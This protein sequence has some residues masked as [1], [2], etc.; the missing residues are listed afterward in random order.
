M[1][2]DDVLRKKIYDGLFAEVV[3]PDPGNPYRDTDTG[4]EILMVDVHG[5]P[6]Q[7]YGAGILYPQRVRQINQL[8]TEEVADTP[9]EIPVV[10]QGD[11]TG[12]TETSAMTRDDASPTDDPVD[13][14]N[15]FMQSAMGFTFM[16][17]LNS[18]SGKIKITASAAHY[19]QSDAQLPMRR[20][21][22]NGVLTDCR[23]RDGNPVLRRC[24]IRRPL[25]LGILDIDVNEV[26]KEKTEVVYRDEENDAWL[27]FQLINRST[28]NDRLAS[29]ATYTATIINNKIASSN[30]KGNYL[31][32]CSLVIESKSDDLIIPYHERVSGTDTAEEKS[33]TLLYRKKHVFAIGHGCA[34]VW[35]SD[36]L[37]V[38]KIST[39]VIPD[40]EMPLV[41]PTS[42]VELS[43]FDLSDLG[44]WQK[45]LQSLESLVTLYGNW[46]KSLNDEANGL[47]PF[48]QDSAHANIEKCSETLERIR[49]GLA[50]LKD[51]NNITALACFK[52][53]NRAMLWQQ[54]RSKVNQRKWIRN[55]NHENTTF[56]LTPLNDGKNV[57]ISLSQFNQTSTAERPVGRWRPFQLAFIL[58]NLKSVWNDNDGERGIIDLIWFPTGGGKTEA[59]LGLTAFQIFSRRIQGDGM[60]KINALGTS[61]IMRYTL[62]LLTVQQY[63]RAASLICACDLIR[64]EN[65]NELGHK[66]ISIG[67][68]VGGKNTPNT[69]KDALAAYNRLHDDNNEAYNFIVL[70]CPC[71]GAQ[72]GKVDNPI[73]Q[74]R[75]KGL[76]RTDGATGRTYFKCENPDCE[77]GNKELPLYV[78]DDE[79]YN[80]SPTLV[81]G[82][83]D[84]FA[85]IP[86]KPDSAK[87]FGFR[88]DLNTHWTRIKPPELI[89]QDELHL[90]SGPLGT[91]VGLYETLVQ[92]LCNN[93]GMLQPP[94][95]PERENLSVFKP[96]KIV[97]SSATIS[98][99]GDQVKALYASDRLNIFPPQAL[100]F[101]NTWFSEEKVISK[102][103]PGRLY[104][105]IC[106]S[107]YPSAQTAI[108]RTYAKVLQTV[109]VNNTVPEID[110][111]WT[112]MGY[113]NSI[114]ELGGA[115]SLVYGDI[116]ERLSQIHA[117]DLIL[118]QVRRMHYEE[119]TSRISNEKI[120]QILKKLETQSGNPDAIAIDICL[121]TNMIATG[122]DISRLGLMFIHG[123]P[124]TTAEYIQASSRVGRAVPSG[125]GF[126]VTLYSPSKPRDK[127]IY[128]HFLAYHAR[129]YANVE[130]T[131][132]TPFTIS[133]RERA[134]HAV[135]IGLIR[136][137]SNGQLHDEALIGNT[138]F[139][140]LSAKVKDIVKKR[141]EFIDYNEYGATSVMIDAFLH[142]WQGGFHY[143]GDAM[144]T[145]ANLHDR[146]PLMY[147]AGAEFP[148]KMKLR[149][150]KTPTSMR[151]VDSESN[152]EIL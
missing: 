133:V 4:E 36:S 30:D 135:I 87:I 60:F 101:G 78:V 132:V 7:K 38:S 1:R 29:T 56:A 94:F 86:W 104:V 51:K 69:N 150:V 114:S 84:K 108:A 63:E 34:A 88:V 67:L 18:E 20:I 43:M 138:D 147:S 19:I 54:Q 73:P 117:R 128:E 46:I 74:T 31:Y 146:L 140:E 12:D 123:Q 131:S 119:L 124:K 57:F 13:L 26:T 48:Y 121:A 64:E 127:S 10:G 16:V 93:Y 2:A 39:S 61:V 142:K 33:M 3:G 145:G 45:G 55:G 110:Y 70:K 118:Q 106:P 44:D 50:F 9:D 76:F 82:T 72:I 96:P 102:E 14:A 125:P 137:F 109:D 37:T 91:M 65:K 47:P 134:L 32:Q 126:I 24:W 28:A 40:Y 80:N 107:G 22:Q 8:D 23:N 152:I 81:L 113:F 42:H 130:P 41:A 35:N 151:G 25:P 66:P 53:M 83:V 148:E 85:M 15:Q 49:G 97:A 11:D 77:Y 141:C 103:Y 79:I 75:I 111:Y 115:A 139:A 17:N 99:A 71:C 95:L 21:D 89:I 27:T 129:I 116:R 92:T 149:S 112:L 5:S 68:W 144:N 136:H 143:Y 59:Y 100:E 98:R 52:W 90:I 105:G 122:V 62:R 58:M 6:W 120:P